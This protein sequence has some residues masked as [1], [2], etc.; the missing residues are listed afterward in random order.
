MSSLIANR[1][2]IRQAVDELPDH[3]RDAVVLRDIEGLPYEEVAERAGIP[4]NTAKTRVARGRRARRREDHR[5]CGLNARPGVDRPLSRSR[6]SSGRRVLGRVPRDRRATRQRG[7]DQAARRPPQPR[8]RDPRALHRRG[9]PAPPRPQSARRAPLR[10]RRDGPTPAVPRAR[11]RAR[12]QPR[13]PPHADDGP[14]RPR[15][16]GRRARSSPRRSPTR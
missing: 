3:Y 2:T 1:A 13:R 8:S 11:A 15:H 4:L 6:A 10:P 12:R 5:G 16:A 9:P 7:R 14:R